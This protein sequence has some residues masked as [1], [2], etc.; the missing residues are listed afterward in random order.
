MTEEEFE[1]KLDACFISSRRKNDLII[2]NA[3][4]KNIA[5]VEYYDQEQV[6]SRVMEL[7]NINSRKDSCY[8]D[9]SVFI[10]LLQEAGAVVI[11]PNELNE[12]N[13]NT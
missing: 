3:V 4:Y 9:K 11:G 13:I 7:M 8:H 2:K 1:I 5:Q 10:C 12:F 6:Y